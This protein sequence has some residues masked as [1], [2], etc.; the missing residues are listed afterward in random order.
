MNK[1]HIFIAG[2]SILVF[3]SCVSVSQHKKITDELSKCQQDLVALNASKND[4]QQ[5]YEAT[6][7][8]LSEQENAIKSSIAQQEERENE[9]QRMKKQVR[10]LQYELDEQQ[11]RYREMISGK[12][13]DLQAMS[14]EL[15]ASRIALDKRAQELARQEQSFIELQKQ[16]QSKEIKMN[17]LQA[18][19]DA[20]EQEVQAIRQKVTDALL[21]FTDKGLSI[22][23]RNGKVYVSMDEKLLF[24]SGSWTVSQEGNKALKEVAKVLEN[25]PDIDVMVEGHT[26]NVPMKSNN[27]VKDN[28]DLSVMRATAIVKILLKAAEI[29]PS[30]IIP[31]GRSQY[32]P[33]TDNSNAADRAK[34]RRTEIILTPK[35]NELLDI[36]K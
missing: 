15:E 9:V 6:Q 26:D 4:L 1:K 23:E 10:D 14:R 30:R 36:L 25:N 19:L 2:I 17:E 18:A 32:V 29:A 33:L 20:K 28:W 8:K 11:S 31:S 13:Q 7:I 12:S 16:F 21:G 24:Q 3:G 27:Q 34:N 35:V 22:D 5:E